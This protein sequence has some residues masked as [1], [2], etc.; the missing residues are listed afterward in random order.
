M[1]LRVFGGLAALCS[2]CGLIAASPGNIAK[3]KAVSFANPTPLARNGELIKRLLSPFAY[4]DLAKKNDASTL[5]ALPIDLKDEKFGLY[6]PTERPVRGYGLLVWVSPLDEAGMPPGWADTLESH[7]VIFVTAARS[8]NNTSP[9]G[10]RIPL[11]LTAAANVAR[12]YPIDSDRVWISGFS[13]GSRIAERMALAYP[14]I[15]SGAI[16]DGS[17]DPIGSAD[18]PLPP[19]ENFERFL[20]RMAIVFSAG[21][22]DE[23]NA[24]S[25]K[26][27]ASGLRR[28]CFD[29]SSVEVRRGEDHVMMNG[30]SL[31]K[32]IEFL[33]R[34][35]DASLPADRQCRQELYSRI[36]AE[37][38]RAETLVRSG[39]H[40]AREAIRDI[41]RRYGRLAAPRSLEL[42]SRVRR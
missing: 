40:S 37:L 6:V 1:K 35:R 30:R 21:E 41:D 15:F 8:G 14:D 31:A 32:A 38:S 33:D 19:R 12:N 11:A 18:V 9:F 3:F 13:G 28:Y 26:R 27:V 36:D 16:L 29:R 5:Q 42:R 7:G 34:P 20:D 4:A 25:A 2:A 22:V 17:S 39:D 24:R 10:R 23:F